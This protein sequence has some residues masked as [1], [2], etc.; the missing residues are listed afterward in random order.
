MYEDIFPQFRHVWCED[1]EFQTEPAG[2]RPRPV[3]YVARNLRTGQTIRFFG[4]FPAKAPFPVGDDTLVVSYYSS[5]EHGFRIAVRWPVPGNTL[6]MYIVFRSLTNGFH[7][8][9]GAGLV[10][11]M[12]H[13]RAKE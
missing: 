10:G 9:H 3:S 2:G 11:A 8:P 4:K 13:S 6:D 1:S 12:A 7:L 5:A